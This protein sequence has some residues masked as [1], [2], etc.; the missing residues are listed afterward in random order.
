MSANNIH[1]GIWTNHSR[2]SIY[3]STLTLRNEHAL[4]LISFLAI[5][6]THTGGRSFKILRFILHQ[7]RS[8]ET[9]RDGLARQQEVILRNGETDMGTLPVLGWI[10]FRWRA[11]AP[12]AWRRSLGPLGLLTLHMFLYLSVGILVSFVAD[13]N[14]P[15][16][17]AKSEDCGVWVG[18][19]SGLDSMTAWQRS[20]L[21]A[22][23]A[24]SAYVRMCYDEEEESRGGETPSECRVLPRRRINWSATHNATCPFRDG[25]CLEGENAAYTM[26]TGLQSSEELGINS[27][28]PLQW[29]H[30]TTC[31]P[32][33]MEGYTEVRRDGKF[34]ENVT[35]Y[36]Y[37]AIR[38]LEN[39]TH[40]VSDWE[41]VGASKGY[42]LNLATSVSWIKDGVFQW[43]PIPPLKRDDADVTLL[44]LSAYGVTYP[45]GERLSFT[46]ARLLTAPAID[47]PIFS[48]HRFIRLFEMP[49]FDPA[50]Q[51]AADYPATV[52]GCTDQYRFCNPRTSRCSP[53]V[54]SQDPGDQLFTI[55][56]NDGDVHV[57]VIIR[58]HMV[59]MNLYTSSIGQAAQILSITN[60][61]Y[62]GNAIG[63]VRE[64]WKVEAGHMFNNGLATAQLEVVRTAKDSYPHDHT[65]LGNALE[66]QYRHV[67]KM[68]VFRTSGYTSISVFWLA[69]ISLFSL[70]I[71]I[72]SFLEG[73]A[74]KVM[75]G[76]FP[77]RVLAWRADGALQLL[78]LIN[79]DK[80]IGTWERG[81]QDVPVTA[82][83]EKLGVVE[84]V[85]GR[86]GISRV[87]SG[88]S[89][90]EVRRESTT[91][92]SQ[93]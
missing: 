45:K 38:T 81:F 64:Q 61:L 68:I 43:E 37:G 36:M 50:A 73:L 57:A 15:F 2:G 51:Y 8:H 11:T 60:R 16:V 63:L 44:F 82:K 49:G 41:R 80:R 7:S 62:A 9:P 65:P 18:Q 84:L 21:R 13:G 54:N 26:D 5:L 90:E 48:A 72:L 77:H 28:N 66:P 14:D 85:D 25:M 52:M 17:R 35:H 93:V 42:V 12:R 31:A 39:S 1:T 89:T 47:D 74:G 20:N 4:A 76:R 67:C 92:S 23:T 53:F 33:K 24:A 79:E 59:Y 32:L 3:G 71:T 19:G 34:G 10:A 70:V 40:T 27:P 83:G 88:I 86:I 55:A 56:E 75:V 91:D 58:F 87:P 30:R 22:S 6:I 46:I 29:Q 78:R 69:C